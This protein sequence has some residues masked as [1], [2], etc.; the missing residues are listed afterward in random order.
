MFSSSERHITRISKTET[1]S[2]VQSTD[3][4]KRGRG[5]GGRE[6]VLAVAERPRDAPRG[7]GN[8]AGDIVLSV[9]GAGQALDSR[10]AAP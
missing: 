8:P 1:D 5:P 4:R 3:R 9:H 10:G 6:G 2:R 7:S